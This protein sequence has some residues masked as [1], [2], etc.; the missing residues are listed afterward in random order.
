MSYLI[1]TTDI[2]PDV[3]VIHC[4]TNNLRERENGTPSL[5][6]FSQSIK[7]SRAFLIDKGCIPDKMRPVIPGRSREPVLLKCDL[8]SRISNYSSCTQVLET[9]EWDL[10]DISNFSATNIPLFY[11]RLIV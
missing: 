9:L 5:L 1:P 11:N 4:G 7:T 10:S 2:Q 3:V 6:L 8:G